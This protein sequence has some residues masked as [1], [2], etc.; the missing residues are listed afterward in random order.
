MFNCSFSDLKI[1][2]NRIDFLEEDM[3]FLDE[4]TK[5]ESKEVLDYALVQA[6][7]YWE[8]SKSLK[9]KIKNSKIT[10]EK[11]K[12]KKELKDHKD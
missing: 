1:A 7:I 10:D 6:S 12:L 11:V 3:H 4:I 9:Q 2:I 5:N 8:K